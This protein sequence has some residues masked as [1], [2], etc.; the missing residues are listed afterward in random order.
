VG[1]LKAIDRFDPA[2]GTTFASF[3][4]PTILGEL[5]RHFRDTTWAVH[6]P[7]KA[8][9]RLQAI[10]AAIERMTALQRVAPTVEEIAQELNLSVEDVLDGLLVRRAYDTD[11]LERP[12]HEDGDQPTVS[13][14]DTVGELEP[15]YEW[16]EQAITVTPA[17]TELSDEERRVLKMR[18]LEE[19]SQSQIA[20]EIGVSQMQVSRM[21]AAT[22]TKI[23]QR[24]GL[25]TQR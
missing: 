13:A 24:A 19:M 10:E 14:I 1:L 18:F 17:L 9:E 23:R 22:I 21:L 3:A 25:P 11:P 7:R 15:G 5:R 8:Q 16:I 4:V 6:V 20:A 2:H 12:Q